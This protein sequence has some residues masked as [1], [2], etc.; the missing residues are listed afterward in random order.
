MTLNMALSKALAAARQIKLFDLSVELF[1][2]GSGPA[3]LFLHAGH[4][5]YPAGRFIEKLSKSFRVLAPS[6][7]GFGLSELPRDVSTVDDIAYV[8]LDLLATLNLRDVM[9]VGCSF[10]A[11]VAAE[12]ATKSTDRLSSL[13]LIDAVGIK[14]GKREDREIL[15]LYTNPSSMIAE[16]TFANPKFA[17][18]NYSDLS[19]E[20]ALRVARNRES[21][22][23]FSFSP[24][25]HNPKLKRRLHRIDCPTLVLWGARDGIAAPDYGRTFAGLIPR[26]HFELIA[27]SGHHPELEQPDLV[28]GKIEAF[29]LENAGKKQG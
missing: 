9:L 14:T 4:G 7:P 3:V 10:G 15:D 5:V 28:A 13:V 29:A 17:T 19:E 20:D 6:H 11:W 16:A 22:L 21:L 1:E 2:Y 18:E 8:Y 12:I 23:F 25:M 27:D 24:Y 26:A